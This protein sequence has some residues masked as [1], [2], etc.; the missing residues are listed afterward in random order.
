MVL[1]RSKYYPCSHRFGGV[2][3]NDPRS[4]RQAHKYNSREGAKQDFHVCPPLF[5]EAHSVYLEL[6]LQVVALASL[7]IH[8]LIEDLWRNVKRVTYCASYSISQSIGRICSS[9]SSRI[10]HDLHVWLELV[11]VHPSIIAAS[12]QAIIETYFRFLGLED[13]DVDVRVCMDVSNPMF[14]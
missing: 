13:E 6:L 2:G 9:M 4:T 7:P 14:C 10:A 11:V 12:S 5:C 3:G 8:E 1:H